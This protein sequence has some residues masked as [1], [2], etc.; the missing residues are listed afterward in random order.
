METSATG[1]TVSEVDP[2]I[3]P[4]VA[5]T[6]LA[7]C[8]TPVARPLLPCVLLIVA[9]VEAEEAQVTCVVRFKVLPSE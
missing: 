7:P 2:L 4:S 1:V 5:L 8:A 9:F 6:V 3:A